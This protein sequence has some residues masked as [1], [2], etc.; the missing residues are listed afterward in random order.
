MFVE[1]YSIKMIYFEKYVFKYA[2]KMIIIITFYK[3]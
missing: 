2:N 1:A 3:E